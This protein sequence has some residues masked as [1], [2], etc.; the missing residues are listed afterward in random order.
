MCWHRLLLFKGSCNSCWRNLRRHVS[1]HL[2]QWLSNRPSQ[3]FRIRHLHLLLLL[4]SDLPTDPSLLLHLH[5][6]R[7]PHHTSIL[8]LLLCCP[9]LCDLSDIPTVII[10]A[11]I[12]CILLL[13]I[14][15]VVV[16]CGDKWSVTHR[17][18]KGLKLWAIL[19]GI[20]KILGFG[21]RGLMLKMI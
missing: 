17:G 21:S 15:I 2:I 18:G 8:L 20:R 5:C 9:S 11:T 7:S 4:Q 10:T 3:C 16:S 13:I 14:I 1:W 12:N 6:P 19:L